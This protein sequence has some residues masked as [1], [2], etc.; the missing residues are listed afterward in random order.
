MENNKLL[1][2]IAVIAGVFATGLAFT[3]IQ[4]AANPG[5][6]IVETKERVLI[7]RND[8][9]ANHVID[10]D[11][12]LSVEEIPTRIFGGFAR[13]C[14][15]AD[16]AESLR[17]ERLGSPVPAGAPLQYAHMK[18]IQDTN[19][20]P[21]TRALGIR[22][23]SENMMGGL[24]VPGDRVDIIATYRLPKEATSR[25]A[26]ANPSIN[27]NDPAS[28]IGSIFSQIADKSAYPDEFQSQEVLSN[29]RIVGVGASLGSSRQQ[30]MFTGE[31]ARGGGGDRIITVEVTP[32][33]AISLIQADSASNN[34]LTLLLRPNTRTPSSGAAGATPS[35]GG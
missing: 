13:L 23:K 31:N 9:P 25:G 2:I 19:L 27:P 18:M 6:V 26:A 10:P 28:A 32:E 35:D 34:N 24:L 30:F 14:F 8:L 7:V 5:S 16:E 12:D 33:Q 22:V 11:R 29:I 1:V 20:A 3:Y 4:S 17:G 15:K 21:G